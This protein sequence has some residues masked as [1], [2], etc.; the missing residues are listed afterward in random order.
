MFQAVRPSV[1]C[2]IH[3]H[4][5][6]EETGFDHAPPEMP[7]H[8]HTHKSL[9]T[10]IVQGLAGSAAIMVLYILSAP[11]LT[12]IF[13]IILFGVGTILGMIVVGLIAGLPL[14]YSA[15]RST[16]INEKIRIVIAGLSIAFGI[17][18]IINLALGL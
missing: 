11:T 12:G 7:H 14:K 16:S 1:S 2:C 15:E 10:G 13:F 8:H 4:S 6:S 18:L 9:L 3:S 5:H 17:W